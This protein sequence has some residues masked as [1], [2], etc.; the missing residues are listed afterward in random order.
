VAEVKTMQKTDDY[1]ATINPLLDF[2]ASNRTHRPKAYN[3]Y[4]GV[5]PTMQIADMRR[6]FGSGQMTTYGAA[7]VLRLF[8]HRAPLMSDVVEPISFRDDNLSTVSNYDPLTLDGLSDV[9]HF[10]HNGLID[11]WWIAL[12]ERDNVRRIVPENVDDCWQSGGAGWPSGG[13]ER[14]DRDLDWMRQAKRTVLNMDRFLKS[15]AD[16]IAE[17]PTATPTQEFLME[18]WQARPY[19]DFCVHH[20]VRFG[21]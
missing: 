12:Y 2:T 8:L 20:S 10:I 18:L 17:V 4:D 16:D 5:T 3:A 15:F 11:D 1:A 7:D 13:F 9:T 21:S 6:V 14:L 19:D